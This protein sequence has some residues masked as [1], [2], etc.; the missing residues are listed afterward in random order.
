MISTLDG[1]PEIGY[2]PDSVTLMIAN[3]SDEEL[4]LLKERYLG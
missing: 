1:T 2:P 3:F 4:A